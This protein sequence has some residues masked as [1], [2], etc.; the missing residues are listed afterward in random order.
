MRQIKTA[1]RGGHRKALGFLIVELAQRRRYPL[2]RTEIAPPAL[3][4]GQ[5]LEL[6]FISVQQKSRE[7]SMLLI[8]VHHCRCCAATIV[9]ILWA[10]TT[11]SAR[12]SAS[13]SRLGPP[14][15]EQNCFGTAT[16]CKFLVRPCNRRPSPPA[17]T[18]AQV[19]LHS[20]VVI[21]MAFSA[22]DVRRVIADTA[23]YCRQTPTLV[24]FLR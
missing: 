13:S 3:G 23:Y 4:H 20:M 15:N 6:R 5:H 18:S 19:S 16:P 21:R 22:P 7:K 9:Q 8:P 24:S 17:S 14:C 11:V 2:R 10:C 12:C 1:V